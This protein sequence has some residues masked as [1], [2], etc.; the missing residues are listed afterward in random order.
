MEK[1]ALLKER[2]ME[3][4]EDIIAKIPALIDKAIKSGAIDVSEYDNTYLVPKY[5]ISAIGQEIRNTYGV[6]CRGGQAD[7]IYQYL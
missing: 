2:T 1:E 6:W 7:N 4:A 5:I 3:L